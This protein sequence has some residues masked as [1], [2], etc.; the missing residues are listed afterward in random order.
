[1]GFAW[2]GVD[3]MLHSIISF[4]DQNGIDIDFFRLKQKKP[5]TVLNKVFEGF[6]NYESLYITEELK[7]R[8][9]NVFIHYTEY[10][11]TEENLTFK[12]SFNEFVEKYNEYKQKRKAA[13]NENWK[14]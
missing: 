11:T 8:C 6:Y 3:K 9:T 7:N 10:E 13:K 12:C 1:M 4:E 2:F 14:M 5:E